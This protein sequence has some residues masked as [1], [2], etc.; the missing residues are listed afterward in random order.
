MVLHKLLLGLWDETYN[1]RREII[2]KYLGLGV[3]SKKA[4]TKT[5]AHSSMGERLVRYFIIGNALITEM[6]TTLTHNNKKYVQ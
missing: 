3:V 4:F 6:K 1:W 2:Y 5:E